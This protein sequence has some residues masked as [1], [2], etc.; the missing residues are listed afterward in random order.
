MQHIKPRKG[1]R[2]FKYLLSYI[3][4]GHR[5]FSICKQF[6]P[7]KYAVKAINSKETSETVVAVCK[8]K[9]LAREI[10]ESDLQGR[11]NG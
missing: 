1:V 9:K 5:L 3:D 10:I 2:V 6:E 11:I 4:E 7:G 8:T